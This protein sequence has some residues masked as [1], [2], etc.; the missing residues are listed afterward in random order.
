[1]SIQDQFISNVA[2]AKA[3]SVCGVLDDKCRQGLLRRAETLGLATTI[4]TW[5]IDKTPR[6]RKVNPRNG[7]VV[8]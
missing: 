8:S 2:Y 3:S 5:L 7:T 4:S 6:A 1:M